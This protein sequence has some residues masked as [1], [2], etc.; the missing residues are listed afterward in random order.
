[1]KRRRF[2]V[3][4]AAAVACAP[5]LGASNAG[6]SLRV[7]LGKGNPAPLAGGG[8]ELNG[9]VYRGT[10]SRVPQGIVNLVALDDYLASV[11]PREM[12][13]SWP[14]S[15]LAMQAICARTF[16]LAHADPARAY[17]VLPS[18]LNQLYEGIDTESSAGRTAVDA[19]FGRVLLYGGA[20]AQVEYSSCC[21]GH[22]ESA[23]DAWGGAP[24]PYLSG[25]VCP[26]CA[27][28]PDF[29][30]TRDIA[31]DAIE[32]ALSSRLSAMGSLRDVRLG[33]KDRSGR[34]REFE[35]LSDRGTAV[36]RGSD[37]RLAV[38]TRIVRSLLIHVLSVLPPEGTLDA[39]ILH[40]EGTGDG[41]GVGLC[42]WG[43][44]GIALL[45]GSTAQMASFYFPG[46][47][48]GSWTS[49]PQRPTST[50]FRRR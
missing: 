49:V 31:F 18:D 14:A 41:H 38:G 33:A 5:L 45:R 32:R 12:P 4:S 20:A 7:L 9:R 37:F 50:I 47:T 3:S 46:T 34:T 16:V 8:F 1:M 6:P 10:F 40:M 28:A 39:P 43:T 26:Y 21:G 22:T 48:I 44:R 11:I 42:Q 2:L 29:Y 35:L 23:S 19:T 24:V 17:D 13:P 25:V 27:D 36:V 30:W 15:A